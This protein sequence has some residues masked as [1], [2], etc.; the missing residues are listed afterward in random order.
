MKKQFYRDD[1][2]LCCVVGTCFAMDE[3]D[4]EKFAAENGWEL[5]EVE[6]PENI[7]YDATEY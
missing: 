1:N 4:L 3:A 5:E 2:N 7:D 6:A